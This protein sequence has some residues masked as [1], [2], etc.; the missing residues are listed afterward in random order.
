MQGSQHPIYPL[1]LVRL[2]CGA[3]S[4][5]PWTSPNS[6]IYVPEKLNKNPAEE[7]TP[8][9]QEQRDGVA[10]TQLQQAGA[11]PAV[12]EKQCPDLQ[13]MERTEDPEVE[14]ASE[15]LPTE[16]TLQ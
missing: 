4:R 15:T 8:A 6:L 3:F 10:K 11:A 12:S 16:P 9:R 2:L 7:G 13:T 5:P 1:I 14:G